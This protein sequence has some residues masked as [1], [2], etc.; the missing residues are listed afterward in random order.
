MKSNYIGNTKSPLFSVV[1][2]TYNSSEYILDALNSVKLQSIHNEL[3]LI[4]TDDCSSDNTI[5][6]C[7]NWLSDNSSCFLK[8]QLIVSQENT[9][10]SAN[11]NRGCVAASGVW[12]K[13]IAGDDALLPDC[14]I[15][16]KDYIGKNP[17]AEIITA[18][19]KVY[20]EKI[21]ESSYKH[22]SKTDEAF[23]SL[24]KDDK[25][26]RIALDNSQ[27]PVADCLRKSTWERLGGYDERYMFEDLSF[28]VNFIESG[29]RYNYLP[30]PIVAYRRNF[31]SLTGREGRL[32]SY[33]YMRDWYRMN[34]DYCFKYAT[35]NVRARYIMIWWLVWLFHHIGLNRKTYIPFVLYHK[36]IDLIIFLTRK[37]EKFC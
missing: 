28:A 2:L 11:L 21:D 8:S 25:L 30:H 26:K 6:I 29:G 4:I 14:M 5:K 9:G 32:F 33:R 1:V 31:S 27:F 18:Q 15:L 7:K 35:K 19:R 16:L 37:N 22:L 20:F 3:E 12:I 34:R 36:S 13:V 10:I 17:N 23:F 24:S